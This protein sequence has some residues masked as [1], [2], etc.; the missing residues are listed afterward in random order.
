[1]NPLVASC[2]ICQTS[3]YTPH[4]QAD[5]RHGRHLQTPHTQFNVAR[6]Q[7]CGLLSVPEVETT[8]DYYKLYY[9]TNYHAGSASSLLT[10]LW[11][12]FARL[13]AHRKIKRVFKGLPQNHRYTV[14]D[15]GCGPGGFLQTLDPQLADAQGLEPVQEAVDA[16]QAQGINVRQG[17]IQNH[18]LPLGA[19]DII[20]LWHVFEHLA[21]PNVALENLHALLKPGGRLIISTPNTQSLAA[22]LGKKYWYHLDVPRHLHLYT[23]HNLAQLLQRHGFAPQQLT[24]TPFDYPLDLFWSIRRHPL[25]ICLLPLYPLIKLFDRQNMTLTAVKAPATK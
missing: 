9:P 1:M 2:P 25:G 8:P 23:P 11:A 24:Y 18:N 21:E 4:F 15:V 7:T 10:R 3:S 17:T 20:T 5:N 22:R 16:A 6:C 13:A 12:P 19:Y 14:L